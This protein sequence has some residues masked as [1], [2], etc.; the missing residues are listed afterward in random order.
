MYEKILDA[1][2]KALD[3]LDT[4]K[5]KMVMDL[6]DWKWATISAG[7]VPEESDIR[8]LARRLLRDCAKDAYYN[9]GKDQFRAT[10]GLEASSVYKPDEMYFEAQIKF[11][12]SQGEY[13][14]DVE[15]TL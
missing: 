8:Q 12:L 1:V 10:G 11:V 3:R 2:D 4:H 5:I 13:S 15:D 6:L 7:E 9:P 14:L